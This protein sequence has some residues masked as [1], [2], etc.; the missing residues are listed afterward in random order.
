MRKAEKKPE[1]PEKRHYKTVRVN[2]IR[3]SVRKEP[4]QDAEIVR[5]VAQGDELEK[6]RDYNGEWIKVPDG[7]V[8]AEFVS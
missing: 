5:I 2:A 1:T 7:Y 6:V 3:L 4:S 8:M